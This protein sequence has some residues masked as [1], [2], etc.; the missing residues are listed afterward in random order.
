MAKKVDAFDCVAASTLPPCNRG[1]TY[2][3]VGEEV[4]Y[5]LSVTW[6]IIGDIYWVCLWIFVVLYIVGKYI[7]SFGGA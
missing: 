3:P 2:Q 6:Y 7:S 1:Q 5:R 4:G